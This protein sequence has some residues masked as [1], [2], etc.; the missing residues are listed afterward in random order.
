MRFVFAAIVLSG[1]T[2]TPAA[3]LSEEAAL[4]SAT[5]SYPTRR[6]VLGS[7]DA[8]LGGV[9]GVGGLI[10]TLDAGKPTDEVLMGLTG[11]IVGSLVGLDGLIR[12][13]HPSSIEWQY[14]FFQKMAPG[15]DKIWES[16]VA[17]GKALLE[18]NAER[19]RT[20]RTIRAVGGFITSGLHLY[21]FSKGQD[22][23]Q[24]LVYPGAVAGVVALYRVFFPSP[25]ES[26]LAAY[27][28]GKKAAWS[29]EVTGQGLALKF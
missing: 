12:L 1:L 23:Y 25:E 20:S 15:G 18:R 26:A 9:T 14:P 10:L 8:I 29:L 24:Y 19:G 28:E 4:R 21:L 13:F 6:Y 2:A 5:E 3:G 7:L 22:R 17:Y 11:T 16:K 27:R